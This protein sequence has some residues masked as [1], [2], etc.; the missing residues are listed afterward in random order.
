METLGWLLSLHFL[1]F[2]CQ[3]TCSDPFT[4]TCPYLKLS[5]Y[6]YMILHM[7]SCELYYWK[8][9]V[10]YCLCI[11]WFSPGRPF[12]GIYLHLHTHICSYPFT[13]T[14][15]YLCTPVNLT[16]GNSWLIAVFA[17]PDFLLS[18]LL[19][20]SIYIYMPIFGTSPLWT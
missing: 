15:C 16:I 1:I 10:D 8:L 9:L 13:F 19:Q 20:W 2:S 3:T 18:D 11:S 12:K 17:F 7:H 4:F 14:W 6:I 5:I